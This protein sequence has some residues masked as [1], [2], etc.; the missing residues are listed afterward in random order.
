MKLIRQIGKSVAVSA[1]VFVSATDAAD[2]Q[3]AS[4]LR[5]GLDTANANPNTR[6]PRQNTTDNNPTDNNTATTAPVQRTNAPQPIQLLSTQP[7]T[8]PAPPPPPRRARQSDPF[9][10][11]GVGAGSF[12]LFPVLE[13]TAIFTDNVRTVGIDKRFDVG[14]RL[15]P[16]LRLQSEWVRH[17]LTFNA[18]S[19][20]IFYAREPALNSHTFNIATTGRLD[21]RRT[22][23]LTGT[24]NYTLS[25]T[26][27]DNSEVPGTAIGNRRD[28]EVGFTA[29]L[30]HR[31]NRLVAT[32]TAGTSWFMYDNVKLAGGGVENNADREYVAPTANLRLAYDV[33]PALTPFVQVGYNPRFHKLRRDR[34]NIVRDSQGFTAS[35]GTA[36]N[37]SPLWDG[38]FSF[39]YEHRNFTDASLAAINAFGVNA[40]INW[41]P[42]QR[43]TVTLVSSTSVDESAGVGRSGTINHDLALDFSHR[44]R[45][46]LTGTLDFGLN[47]DD[48]AGTRQDDLY[49]TIQTG[50]SYIIR[51]NME[52]IANYQMTGFF[53]G[54]KTGSYLE[55]RIT[56]G[57]RFRL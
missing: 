48:F 57:V 19:E 40:A 33:S 35:T 31:M 2:A 43:T 39:S 54:A 55:N 13:T 22:T 3:Q 21:I 47:Y 7:Q 37:F 36:F 32:L 53:A 29:A 17:S 28:H 26:S 27:N 12:R 44:F 6:N 49:L 38:E 18:S 5:P 15:A 9:A 11:V 1:L 24:A 8:P 46:N 25:Q 42:S 16:S 41:R 10:P 30:S 50:F 20:H 34:N 4:L 45:E 14:L 56:T 23:S 51:R 52:W